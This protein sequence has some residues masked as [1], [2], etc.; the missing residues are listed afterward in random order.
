[1][2]MAWSQSKIT[3]PR[4]RLTQ[5][6][7]GNDRPSGMRWRRHLMARLTATLI[8]LSLLY[9]FSRVAGVNIVSRS[10]EH[11][12]SPHWRRSP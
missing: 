7:S 12:S 5:A 3:T 2:P 11:G 1:M 8:A 10:I 6:P 9:T 4:C